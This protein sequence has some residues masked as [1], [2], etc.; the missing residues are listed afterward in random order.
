M[1]D[2]IMFPKDFRLNWAYFSIRRYESYIH[3]NK[4]LNFTRLNRIA[5]V[6]FDHVQSR[7]ECKYKDKRD[8]RRNRHYN[9]MEKLRDQQWYYVMGRRNKRK[10]IR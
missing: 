1:R 8:N 5:N 3:T 7:S 10:R 6:I 4:R 9:F 2:G